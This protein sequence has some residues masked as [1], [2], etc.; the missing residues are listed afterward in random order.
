MRDNQAIW[1]RDVKGL[2]QGPYKDQ[3]PKITRKYYEIG[4]QCQIKVEPLHTLF[5]SEKY[6][7]IKNNIF[8]IHTFS[9]RRAWEL[10]SRKKFAIFTISHIVYK[11]VHEICERVILDM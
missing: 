3:D 1:E 10:K 11:E 6:K 8:N 4:Q 9:T 5:T 7:T 2:F